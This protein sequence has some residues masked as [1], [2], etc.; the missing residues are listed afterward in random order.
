MN[1]YFL[2]E[3][4]K[5][6]YTKP[7]LLSW[8][9]KISYKEAYQK[10]YERLGRRCLFF[11]EHRRE[12]EYPDMLFQ[13]FEMVSEIV[14]DIME[15]YEPYVEFK[16]IILLDHTTKKIKTYYIPILKKIDCIGPDS[17]FNLDHSI[18]KE[19]FIYGEK[20][21]DYACFRIQDTPLQP[22]VMRGDMMELLERREIKGFH[23]R[24]IEL[25]EQ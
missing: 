18:I 14:K 17:K 7:V 1:S 16:E 8:S 6:D 25:E 4:E 23:K 19:P 24:Q 22:M 10:E 15:A 13:P 5:K 20:A 3:A 11:V 12:T 21:R 9:K 2:V